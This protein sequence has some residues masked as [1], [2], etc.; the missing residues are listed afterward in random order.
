M[1]H[2]EDTTHPTRSYTAAQIT[3]AVAFAFA[4]IAALGQFIVFFLPDVFS[5]LV[6]VPVLSIAVISIV[7]GLVTSRQANGEQAAQME[8]ERH[9]REVALR[10]ES[11]TRE[12][13]IRSESQAREVAILGE[14][15]AR[16]EGVFN[17]KWMR[18]ITVWTVAGGLVLG[19]FIYL[20]ALIKVCSAF[21]KSYG[22][23]MMREIW[24]SKK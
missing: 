10:N 4:F 3:A 24:E 17:E 21:G 6:L 8:R 19:T 22:E 11:Q 1:H 13:A 2:Q 16:K 15:H 9:V 18:E 12:K 7:V 5:K 14:S 23:R 20:V